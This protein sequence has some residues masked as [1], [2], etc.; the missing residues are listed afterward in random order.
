MRLNCNGRSLRKFHGA[1]LPRLELA[2]I[3]LLGLGQIETAAQNGETSGTSP[4]TAASQGAE[5]RLVLAILRLG[6]SLIGQPGGFHERQVP[7]GGGRH[8]A[9]S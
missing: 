9:E 3:G 5:A 4:P 1:F 8:A 2:C 7:R 6:G